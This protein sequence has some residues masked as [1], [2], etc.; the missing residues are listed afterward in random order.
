MNKMKIKDLTNEDLLWALDNA[1]E[2]GDERKRKA[3]LKEIKRR[4][5][6]KNV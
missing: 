1:I 2:K 5:I 4:G 6:E 3:I